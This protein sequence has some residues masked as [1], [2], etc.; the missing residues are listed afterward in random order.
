MDFQL[1]LAAILIVAANLAESSHCCTKMCTVLNW[2]RK[3][4][5]ENMEEALLEE[6]PDLLK[7]Q[8]RTKY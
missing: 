2:A 8:I 5:K 6:T 3:L 7:K 1:S 4:Q